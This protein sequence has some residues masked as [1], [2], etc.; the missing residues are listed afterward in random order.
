MTK[1]IITQEQLNKFGGEL[2]WAVVDAMTLGEETLQK[3]EDAKIEDSKV[4]ILDGAGNVVKTI[5]IEVEEMK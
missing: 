1:I 4:I 3:Y 5:K 2:D